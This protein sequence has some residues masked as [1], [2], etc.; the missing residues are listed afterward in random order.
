MHAVQP[1]A[2]GGLE[3]LD[4]WAWRMAIWPSHTLTER[5]LLS[6][7]GDGDFADRIHGGPAGPQALGCEDVPHGPPI[8]RHVYMPAKLGRPS[9]GLQ[10]P[11]MGAL[12]PCG[13]KDKAQDRGSQRPRAQLKPLN[14]TQQGKPS[15]VR[16]T[17][18]LRP[19]MVRQAGGKDCLP[20]IPEGAQFGLLKRAKH[21]EASLGPANYRHRSFAMLQAEGGSPGWGLLGCS[22]HP[23]AQW[24]PGLESLN[25]TRQVK[26][27][28]AL[29]G[30]TGWRKGSTCP[31]VQRRPGDRSG[32]LNMPMQG[33][34]PRTPS[35]V[36]SHVVGQRTKPRMGAPI[37]R[38][39][40]G[41]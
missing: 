24:S 5:P 26:P 15:W 20:W 8:Q 16:C 32:L 11:V 23:G 7:A 3:R 13:P 25:P 39:S 28:R 40:L 41:S 22:A 27:P 29:C 12:P 34:R 14:P 10:D 18:S 37:P 30:T 4:G 36:P 6:F 31:R 2:P 38:P 17:P 1:D 19:F 33:R 35:G 9:R 21:G